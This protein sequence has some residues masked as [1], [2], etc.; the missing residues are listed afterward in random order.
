M[1]AVS[2]A[3]LVVPPACLLTRLP[4]HYTTYVDVDVEQLCAQLRI[5][6]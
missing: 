1:I 5:I 2:A 6:I 4:E 3:A